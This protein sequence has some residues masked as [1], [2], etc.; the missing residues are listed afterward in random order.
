VL[1]AC[2]IQY[3]MRFLCTILLATITGQAS[4]IE[5]K[6]EVQPA[7]AT[8]VVPSQ[9]HSQPTNS[10]RASRLL[11]RALS[12]QLGDADLGTLMSALAA[13]RPELRTPRAQLSAPSGTLYVL[14]TP[15]SALGFSSSLI[16]VQPM[17][18]LMAVQGMTVP[19]VA[20]RL[21]L[22]PVPFSPSSRSVRPNVSVIAFDLHHAQLAGRVLVGC[23][24]ALPGAAGWLGAN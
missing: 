16:L 9:R 1:R 11:S 6:F 7:A 19:R 12:C 15:V 4:G 13:E 24:Y 14:A 21:L 17:R 8:P 2:L 18:I 20:G 23:E 5:T 22:E 10:R 3:T